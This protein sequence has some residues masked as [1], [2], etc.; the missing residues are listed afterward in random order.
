MMID[1]EKVIA[2]AKDIS[3][4]WHSQ[5]GLTVGPGKAWVNYVDDLLAAIEQSQKRVAELE[6]KLEAAE[7]QVKKYDDISMALQIRKDN[8]RERV[9]EL[10]GKVKL[11]EWARHDPGCNYIDNAAYGCRCGLLKAQQALSRK[12]GE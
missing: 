9:V 3:A 1:I 5:N 4:R 11:A 2:E 8:L 12:D 10:E 6:E 7:K